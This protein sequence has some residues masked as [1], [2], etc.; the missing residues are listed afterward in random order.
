MEQLSK[1]AAA[2]F[3]SFLRTDSF[4]EKYTLLKDLL[5]QTGARASLKRNLSMT[6]S[7]WTVKDTT[8]FS[9]YVKVVRTEVDAL[10]DL[11]GVKEQVDRGI[12]SDLK[13]MGW[14]PDLTGPAVRQDW[15]KLRLIREARAQRGEDVPWVRKIEQALEERARGG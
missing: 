1:H 11:M 15:E 13:S 3:K 8:R 4:R 6:T 2:N 5:N 10:I 9:E 7:H 12:R 14:H